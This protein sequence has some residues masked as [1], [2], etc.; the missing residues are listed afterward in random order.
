MSFYGRFDPDT[1]EIQE[2]VEEAHARRK[3][4]IAGLELEK[5]FPNATHRRDKPLR[6]A[7]DGPLTEA[8]LIPGGSKFHPP[9]E[10]PAH[11]WQTDFIRGEIV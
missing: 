9:S 4:F 8:A 3:A 2:T 10:F 6:V 7:H 5:K 1:G 11:L